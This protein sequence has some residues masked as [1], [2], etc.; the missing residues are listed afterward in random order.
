MFCS[1]CGEKVEGSFCTN[2]GTPAGQV[3]SA[4]ASKTADNSHNTY[5]LVVGIIMVVLGALIF[6][7]TLN[8]E[9][10]AKYE[11]IGYDV[12]LG[13]MVPGIAAAVGGILS[14]ISR[15]NNQMLLFSSIAYIAAAV[16]NCIGIKDV[17]IL[18]I[19][20]VV[21]GIINFVFY[22]KKINKITRAT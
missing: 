16:C 18:F 19:L 5:R 2:C 11:L 22:S 14:I 8:D 21:F 4:P 3:I 1:K 9:T 12:T 13:F 17:S 7:A 15:N 10:V 6:I 20:S